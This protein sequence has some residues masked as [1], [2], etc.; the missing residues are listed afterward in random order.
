MIAA[1]SARVVVVPHDP[2]DLAVL[3]SVVAANDFELRVLEPGAGLLDEIR[4]FQP[5]ATVLDVDH[6]GPDCYA[7]CRAIKR[8]A[9]AGT[10]SVFL[11]DSRDSRE[12][13]ARAYDAG[14][15]DFLAKP[16]DRHQL[17][18]RLQSCA[19]LRRRVGSEAALAMLV[20]IQRTR[21]AAHSWL[22]AATT[23]FAAMLGLDTDLRLALDYAAALHDV[24]ELALPATLFSSPQSLTADE[25]ALVETHPELGEALLAAVAPWPT[26]L[27]IVRHHHERW[28]GTGYPD[29]L[30]GKLI[31]YG[32]RVFRVLD[33][34]D[35]LRS[36]RPH[37]GPFSATQAKTIL[38]EEGLDPEVRVA[39]DRWLEQ[40]AHEIEP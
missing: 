19:R 12:A 26:L 7:L 22:T 34:Y 35:A 5:D 4:R 30:A 36:P 24:G 37:R 27:E 3:A 16:L 8:D 33:V 17:A 10:T 38:R 40:H 13:R 29:R 25:R 23:S 1:S 15:D 2:A 6:R 39:F 18:Y 14:C 21:H 31:P 20:R 28:D 9:V 11:I 32:A